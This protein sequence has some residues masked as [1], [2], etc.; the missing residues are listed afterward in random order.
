MIRNIAITA[1]MSMAL[2]LPVSAA[3]D[4]TVSYEAWKHWKVVGEA[5]LSWLFFDVYRSELLAPQGTYQLSDD[6]SPHPV[7]LRIQYQRDI[8]RSQLLEATLD[9][10]EKMGVEKSTRSEWIARL[11]DVFPDIK[12]GQQLIYVTDGSQGSFYYLN[13]DA[14]LQSVGKITDESLNDGFLGIW[15]AS[16]SQYPKLRAQLIG[17]N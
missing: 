5:Q 17:M 6:V 9:Q 15:L 4:K 3:G 14:P 8:S 2:A 1:L 7:A 11:Y 13:N 16:N 12:E 10:W